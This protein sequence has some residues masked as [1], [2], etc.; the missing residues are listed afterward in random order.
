[1]EEYSGY[2]VGA[3]I[4]LESLRPMSWRA[5]SEFTHKTSPGAPVRAETKHVTHQ[6]F[7][8]T[9]PCT[10]SCLARMGM[11]QKRKPC[12]EDSV[13]GCSKRTAVPL[14]SAALSWHNTS[15]LVRTSSN[16]VLLNYPIISSCY[17]CPVTCC[18]EDFVGVRVLDGSSHMGG[19]DLVYS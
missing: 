10:H 13:S 17:P 8:P 7:W 19:W 2:T 12:F 9:E 14:S 15:H 4:H 3:R 6:W 1:M 16:T 5:V 18:E 11:G